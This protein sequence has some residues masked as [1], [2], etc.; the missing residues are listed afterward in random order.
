M[1]PR[2]SLMLCSEEKQNYYTFCHYD[3]KTILKELIGISH[4][5]SKF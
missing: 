5:M 1:G 2:T 3:L 4:F